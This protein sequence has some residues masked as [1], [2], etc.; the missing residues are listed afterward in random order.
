MGLLGFIAFLA[1]LHTIAEGI[2]AA[3]RVLREVNRTHKAAWLA[4]H[5]KSVASAR[6]AAG[7][8]TAIHGPRH[9]WRAFRY[10]W[11]AHYRAKRDEIRA[12]YAPAPPPPSPPQ[13]P[14]PPT[15]PTGWRPS[16]R[17]Q[18]AVPPFL[19]E[20]P[21]PA[22]VHPIRP[23]LRL[24]EPI[25]EGIPAMAMATTEITGIAGLRAHL[26]DSVDYARALAEDAREAVNRAQDYYDRVAY[27]GEAA[28][29]ILDRD[30]ETAGTI[31]GLIEPAQ[32]RLDAEHTRLAAADH[33][34]A[35]AQAALTQLEV[36]EATA[37]AVQ[38]NP[39][40]SSDTSV[41][42]DN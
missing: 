9:A 31:A 25:Q 21:Q 14:R 12:R 13:P 24:V 20:L 30:P 6:W 22:T 15:P 1:L 23:D 4:K 40:V 17:L 18:P 28:G 38:A 32:Q 26:E 36:H 16:P 27:A 7:L 42:Q 41:Y 10:D 34:L 33:Q 11:R 8:A 2:D 3:A 37:E 39:H 29:G 19:P 35:Q 5:P